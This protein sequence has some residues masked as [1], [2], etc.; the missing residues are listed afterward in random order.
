[1]KYDQDKKEYE[2]H[3]RIDVDERAVKDV[4]KVVK[5]DE[6]TLRKKEKKLKVSC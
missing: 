2:F 6:K 3:S 1:M 5:M 4:V